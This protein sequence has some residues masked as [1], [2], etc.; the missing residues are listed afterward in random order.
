ITTVADQYANP[1]FSPDGT[2]IVYLKG[3][4]AIYRDENLASDNT[5]ELHY[6]DGQRHQYVM[7]L[8][9]SGPNSRMPRLI[10]DPQ[11][12]RIYFKETPP[13]PAPP[14]APAQLLTFLSSVK[15]TGDDY[16]RHVETRFG[17]EIVPS[18]DFQWV[19]FKELHKLYVAPMPQ[20]GKLLRLSSTETSLP[21]KNVSKASGDWLNWS[22]DSKTVQWTLGENFYEQAIE[23]VYAEPAKDVKIG[24]PKATKIGFE[25]QTAKPRG[26]VALTNAR[27]ITMKG[28]QVIERGTVLVEDNRIKAVG[29]SVN[30]PAGARR[31][32]MAGKTIAP[33]IVDVHAHMGYS[34]LD[35]SPEREWMYYA[36]LAYGVT[37]T[38]DPSASTQTVFAQSELVKSG[39]STGPR[40]FSTGY[41]LY[42][43]ESPEK[44]VVNSLDDARAHLARHK[45][46]GAF[47]VKS[48]NQPRRNQRQQI[49]QAAREL[50][51]MVVPEGGSTYWYQKSNVWEN[52]RLLQF[53]PRGDVDARS[54]RRTMTPDDDFIHFD[55][56][57]SV[58]DVVR[59]GGKAQ[60]GAHGQLQ[61]LGAHWE[62]WMLQQ[63]GLTPMEALRA[64]TLHGAEY[65]GLDGDLGSIEAGKLADFMITAK[66]PLDNIQNSESV[67]HVMINGVLFDARNMDEVYPAAAPRKKF[68]W[69]R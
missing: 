54:R 2:K 24:E 11:G 27:I 31:I 65:L 67:S 28:D 16:K 60:L 3:R 6:W 26:L 8:Q 17:T 55:L 53:T 42:G 19:F 36:N 57:R 25:F 14:G 66:N 62:L 34:N 37:T 45:A 59:A 32:D 52:A 9:T 21:V 47:S 5:F 7:D 61:G 64:A 15:T 40:V 43:A 44:A 1:A 10:F 20:L 30:V 41:P 46:L 58:R 13:S 18:P 69:E 63:G 23:Q 51:M 49:I 68:Y 22:T 38:H 33:G 4:G 29:A 50:K 39:M 35:I 56:A 12:E 48:Y